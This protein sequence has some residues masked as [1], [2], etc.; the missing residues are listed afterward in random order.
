MSLGEDELAGYE[1]MSACSRDLTQP[2]RK[3]HAQS[4]PDDRGTRQFLPGGLLINGTEILTRALG[5]GTQ[6]Q[7]HPQVRAREI[8]RKIT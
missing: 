8:A 2:T 1:A 5:T 6:P 4:P 7:D 3:A